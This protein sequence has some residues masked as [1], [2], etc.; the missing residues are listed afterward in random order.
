MKKIYL[1][2]YSQ[3]NFGDDL[4]IKIFSDY[5]D[6]CKINLLV[7]PMH[8][9]DDLASNV[10]VHPFSVLRTVLCKIQSLCGYESKLSVNLQKYQDRCTKKISRKNDAVVLIGGSVFMERAS[11]KEQIMFKTMQYPKFEINSC[12]QNKGNAFIVGANLGPAYS[13]E[14]WD[15]IKNVFMDYNHVCLRDYSSYCMVK[16]LPHVQ[17]APD[18]V[19]M[20]PQPEVYI[21]RE[22]VV[23]SVIDIE[24]H[25]KKKEV[26][27][28]YYK[29]LADAIM[30]FCKRDITVTLVSF[31]QREGDE[32]SIA[33]VLNKV[34]DCTN[35]KTCFYK[36][37][38][39]L[40]LKLFAEATFIIG[41]RFHSIILGISYGKP[42]FPIAYNCK[43]EHYLHDLHFSGKYAS[44]SELPSLSYE[45]LIYNYE[46][47]IV[48][49]CSEHKRYAENQFWGL[50]KYLDEMN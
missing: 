49:D 32:E 20:A 30:Y 15:G 43:I 22:M 38:I 18:V 11:K 4:F 31:C 9:P 36:G 19:F 13:A 2:F 24:R 26:V 40:I 23:I 21:K 5:F 14:Y 3:A 39:E 42:V 16:D 29:L 47:K 41:S 50:R 44:L 28:A 46:R 1:Q 25:S 48:T 34:P 35:V 6:D 17:Y 7:N 27:F 37:N 33:K 45:D 12:L 8:I 10:R